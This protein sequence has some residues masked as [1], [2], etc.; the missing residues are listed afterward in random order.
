MNSSISGKLLIAS[1]YLSDPNFMRSVVL[2]VS[3]DEQGA[4]GLSLTRPTN[5]RLSDIVEMSLPSAKIRDDDWIYEGGP[6]DGPLLAVHSMAG[7][8]S[9]VVDESIAIWITSE[10][11]H[12]RMLLTRT[13]I[14]V[15]FAAKYSGWG[16]GQLDS[17]LEAGGWLVGPAESEIVFEDAE[18]VWESSV[19]RCGHDVLSSIS[20]GLRIDDPS[21]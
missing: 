17:E 7:V 10:E 21:V 1:P 6:V 11:E 19:K 3:H 9:P 18:N 12:L 4:F 15:R 5:R 2:I 20:P 14:Q 8:G 16:P 13:D